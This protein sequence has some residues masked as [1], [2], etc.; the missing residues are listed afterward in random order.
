LRKHD[1]VRPFS[2]IPW[3]EEELEGLLRSQYDWSSGEDR[4]SS[5]WRMGD[6]TAPFYN[7]MYQI[8]LGMTE[9]DTL[10]SNQV[11][12]GLMDRSEAMTRLETDNRFNSLGL[13]S[14]FVTVGI[15]LEWAGSRIEEFAHQRLSHDNE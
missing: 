7:L 9:H 15:D 5:S 13:A 14:Y 6:G 1:F 10:R 2:Y 4:S 11:R 12:F 8:G 3:E